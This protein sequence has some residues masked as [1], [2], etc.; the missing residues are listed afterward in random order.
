MKSLI[1]SVLLLMSGV[2]WAG[3]DVSCLNNICLTTGWVEFDT[4]TTMQNFVFCHDD[5]ITS[6]C[7][8]NGW[9]KFNQDGTSSDVQCN[10][11]SC[12]TEGY[13]EY[14]TTGGADTLIRAVS[15]LP[16]NPKRRDCL[17]TGWNEYVYTNSGIGK[18][19]EQYNV[20]CIDNNCAQNGWVKY[21]KKTL[22]STTTC[23]TGGCFIIG[24]I[25]VDSQ[26]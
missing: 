15:C 8:K 25:T 13:Q 1:F 3:V 10:N 14:D 24:W 2:A 5:S 12:F 26:S 17:T 21:L 20:S 22:V 16:N 9:V 7:A 4:T 19:W 18:G 6:N 23:K 11:S